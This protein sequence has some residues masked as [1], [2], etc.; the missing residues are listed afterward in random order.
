MRIMASAQLREGDYT[1]PTPSLLHGCRGKRG[2]RE[3]LAGSP[4]GED[5][6]AAPPKRGGGAKAAGSQ[7]RDNGAAAPGSL[8]PA[9]PLTRQG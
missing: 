7:K 5:S 8:L 4:K 2:G 6:G 9:R 3:G 1:C